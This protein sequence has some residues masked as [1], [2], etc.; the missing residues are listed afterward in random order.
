MERANY[1][2]PVLFEQGCFFDQILA[3]FAH[4]RLQRER[5]RRIWES[6]EHSKCGDSKGIGKHSE[7]CEWNLR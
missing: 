2:M 5:L 4:K 7:E 3:I 1:F 6:G